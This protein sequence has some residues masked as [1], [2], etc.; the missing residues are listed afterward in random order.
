MC[1]LC[2]TSDGGK[3]NQLFHQASAIRSRIRKKSRRGFQYNAFTLPRQILRDTLCNCALSVSIQWSSRDG[4]IAQACAHIDIAP[5]RSKL[6]RSGVVEIDL[7][8]PVTIS[9][10]RAAEFIY[11]LRYCIYIRRALSEAS[12]FPHL[13]IESLFIEQL[14]RD[15]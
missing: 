6:S 14:F 8:A 1:I 3:N 2:R 15:E 11:A 9:R 13:I 7:N 12:F 10:A 5:E 4:E